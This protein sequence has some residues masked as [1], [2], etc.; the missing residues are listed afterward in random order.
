M[1]LKGLD[2]INL[3]DDF[4]KILKELISS[5]EVKKKE[6]E[7]RS[8]VW[9]TESYQKYMDSIKKGVIPKGNSP[10][11]ENNTHTKR[12]ELS[13]QHTPE[14]INEIKKCKKDILYFAN[15]YIFAKTKIG[16]EKITMRDYQ[17]R[18]LKDFQEKNAI[19]YLA[20][21]QSGKSITT[22]IFLTWYACFHMDKNI[23]LVS[24]KLTSS[25]DLLKK[26]KKIYYHL[27]F[28][29][30]PGII[31]IQTTSIFDN[32]CVINIDTTTGFSGR[33]DTIDI[34]YLDEY[35][36]IPNHIADEFY[37][38]IYPTISANYP[39]CKI[40]ITST[41]NP[42]GG[43][44]HFRELFFG[45]KEGENDYY[46]VVV[47]YWEVPGRDEEWEKRERRNIG[48]EKFD[49]EY[50]LNFFS[51]STRLL[52]MAVLQELEKT[53]TK[54][55]YREIE[56]L[57]DINR[58]EQYDKYVSWNPNYK[59]ED[60]TDKDQ[61]VISIDLGDGEENDYSVANIFKIEPNYNINEKTIENKNKEL[62]FFDLH[63]YGLIKTNK[64]SVEKFAYVIATIVANYF[65]PDNVKI[66][67][68]MNFKGESFMMKFLN[69]EKYND[70]L[71][72]D[73]FIMTYHKKD[74]KYKK[75][76]VKVRK[77]E[78]NEYCKLYRDLMKEK[79]IYIYDEKTISQ[80][81]EFTMKK[82]NTFSG[83]SGHND[84]IVMTCINLTC[85][86]Y[87]IFNRETHRFR[88]I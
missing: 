72:E 3:T 7:G 38:S 10:F 13:F 68:E 43:Q 85:Y 83:D 8:I 18:V 57:F 50:G 75:F 30:K 66:V 33:G 46:P 51:E 31:D 80:N 59:F 41:P 9:T 21:R 81:I 47:N 36:F 2:K 29:M 55:E 62:D 78:K 12:F 19:I 54:F 15:K 52:P 11:F 25:K 35:A 60:M 74:A 70:V 22:A 58:E 32:G 63:Q 53:K 61:F 79:R 76:G 49:V 14:E 16:I 87:D 20:S 6:D 26:L 65:N 73:M 23:L 1:K 44:N 17:N 64:I 27:P 77:G 28:F 37:Q 84:D 71:Y 45:T 56:E 67:L 69:Y 82:N 4:D 86:F 40:I 42:S 24:K 88:K 39:Y 48:D 5:S 34:L